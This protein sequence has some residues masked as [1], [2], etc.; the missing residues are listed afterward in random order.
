VCVLPASERTDVEAALAAG[1]SFRNIA[2]QRPTLS[3]DSLRRHVNNGHLPESMQD[4]VE[5]LYGLDATTI[6]ARVFDIAQRARLVAR[7]AFDAGHHSTVLRAGDAETRAL[8]ALAGMN[9]QHESAVQA[10]ETFRVTAR[11][12]W[13]AAQADPGYA[14]RVAAE[15]D[16]AGA[17]DLA[18]DLRRVHESR[19]ALTT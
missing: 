7:E 4:A 5:R 6:A 12:A 9:V 3:R 10:A 14:E 8:A 13:R 2:R 1:E 16:R 19:G 17:D 11:A 15:L 18:A